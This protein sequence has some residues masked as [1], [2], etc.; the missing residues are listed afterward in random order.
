VLE[1][2]VQVVLGL[3]VHLVALL[4]LLVILHLQIYHSGS[5]L[6]QVV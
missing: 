1:F 3:V 5:P 6:L 2:K 4:L